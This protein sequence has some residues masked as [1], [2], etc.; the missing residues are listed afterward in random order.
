M[1]DSEGTGKINM[2]DMTLAAIHK[3]LVK[4]IHCADI[5][6]AHCCGNLINHKL[7]LQILNKMQQQRAQSLIRLIL[8]ES[9]MQHGN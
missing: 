2:D 7:K 9:I 3:V 4:H 5:A 8:A 6:Q 1:K